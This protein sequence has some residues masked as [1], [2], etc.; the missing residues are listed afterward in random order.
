M[1]PS[2]SGGTK[3][4]KK[5]KMSADRKTGKG[6]VTKKKSNAKDKKQ[7]ERKSTNAKR[8]KRAKKED[9]D[10]TESLDNITP[11]QNTDIIKDLDS[12]GVSNGRVYALQPKL[13]LRDQIVHLC[14][15]IGLRH[16]QMFNIVSHSL[17]LV[18]VEITRAGPYAHRD[19]KLFINTAT[20]P[21]SEFRDLVARQL[22]SRSICRC[23]RLCRMICATTTNLAAHTW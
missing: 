7:K 12:F 10:D 9:D 18:E 13:S 8:H 21:T 6:R 4:P 15:D 3:P 17:D 23:P 20:S 19:Y 11:A 14:H 16:S 22:F 2:K 5:P 1:A